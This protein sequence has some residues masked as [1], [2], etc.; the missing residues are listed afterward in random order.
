M[1]ALLSAIFKPR[2]DADGAT[3]KN[4]DLSGKVAMMVIVEATRVCGIL[5][6]ECHGLDRAL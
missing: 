6:E 5:K 4:V 3:M 2:R 1:K